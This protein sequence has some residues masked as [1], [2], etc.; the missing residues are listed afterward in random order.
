MVF[1]HYL[2][3][4]DQQRETKLRDVEKLEKSLGALKLHFQFNKK[5]N[6]HI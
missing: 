6:T 2:E 1:V 5:L 4:H 3:I